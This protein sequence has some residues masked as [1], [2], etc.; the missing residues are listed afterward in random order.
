MPEDRDD[1]LFTEEQVRAGFVGTAVGMIVVLVLM[2]LLATSRP[3]G[4][5]RPVDDQQFRDTVT[6][7]AQ[8]LDGYE[9]VGETRARIDVDR[10][11]EL[12]AERGVELDLTNVQAEAAQDEGAVADGAP[13]GDEA[14]GQADEVDGAEVYAANCA[15][16][17]QANG[18]GVPGAFPP[19]ANG[20]VPDLLASAGGRE[21]LVRAVVFGVQGPID[22]QGESYAGVMPAWRQLSNAE[23]AAVLNHVATD[24]D[25]EAAL[26][27]AF[28]PF[29]VEDVTEAAEEDLSPDEVLDLRP[30]LEP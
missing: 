7:A 18:A 6:A 13:A 19:L 27:D 9:R 10:A 26:P 3:Q 25:N 14:V 11:M 15:A 29:G 17:H 20:H 12:V 21:Y 8:K 23:I 28:E 30:E 22:V 2:L 4:A 16:C 5:L 1:R 24:W